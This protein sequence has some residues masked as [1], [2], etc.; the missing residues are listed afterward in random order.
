[1]KPSI[2]MKQNLYNN[3]RELEN[4]KEKNEMKENFEKKEKK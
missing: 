4:E 1:M 2:L 3:D